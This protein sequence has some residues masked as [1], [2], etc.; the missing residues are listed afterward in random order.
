[1]NLAQR[2]Y[3]PMDSPSFTLAANPI[4][5]SVGAPI[6]AIHA[7]ASL[8]AVGGESVRGADFAN[9]FKHLMDPAGRQ[10][11]AAATEPGLQSL[12][13]SPNLDLITADGPLPDNASLLAFARGQ[14]LDDATL[15]ALFAPACASLQAEA[16]MAQA[17]TLPI[18]EQVQALAA[19]AALPTALAAQ[20]PLQEA[21]NLSEQLVLQSVTVQ[22]VS[23]VSIPQ[24]LRAG[25][26]LSTASL[27]SADASPSAMLTAAVAARQLAQDALKTAGA[28]SQV[29]P[30][31]ALA[32][33]LPAVEQAAE[34]A[35]VA[36]A[37]VFAEAAEAAEVAKVAE[38]A[39][40]AEAA[41][42]AKMA[43]A[44]VFAEAAEVAEAAKAEEVARVAPVHLALPS[45]KAARTAA[46]L[47]AEAPADA[48]ALVP[49]GADSDD[50]AVRASALAAAAT[51]ASRQVLQDSLRLRL[52]PQQAI[53]QRL[54]AM[55]ATGEQAMWKQISAQSVG[56]LETLALGLGLGPDWGMA[57]D[58]NG[59]EAWTSHTHASPAAEA[60]R[61]QAAGSSELNAPASTAAER[62]AQY[63]QLAQRL[64]RALGE[65]LQAQ[66]QRG[67]W[68]VHLQMDPAALGRI[69]MELD[70]RA[71]GLDAV[72]RSDN[73]LTRELIA[74]SL[75]RLRET[76]SQSGT[77]VANVWVQGESQRQSG[78]NPTPGRQSQ[79]ERGGRPSEEGA[80]APQALSSRPRVSASDWD[81]LA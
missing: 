48:T 54:A 32:V 27:S 77:A 29:S 40:F 49:A 7:S 34:V 64:G 26:E 70:M 31:V 47:A 61:S 17:M 4:S 33:K 8:P 45:A 35:K 9:L 55:A 43:E 80:T 81:M 38:A 18:S 66:I 6:G 72:F 41:E 67:E 59:A 36:E 52:Q 56:E 57:E 44:A 13:L 42:V 20:V 11:L 68:K 39:V 51:L 19:S 62:V 79:S 10:D 23:A 25:T 5:T 15:G 12:A 73:P 69:D 37:A 76:L 65:R 14:G 46:G 2:A 60:L 63:E 24:G 58:L 22:L 78:G 28:T 3:H 50:P 21:L 75:P 71:G 1:M 16:A 30:A 53:T 74:Q